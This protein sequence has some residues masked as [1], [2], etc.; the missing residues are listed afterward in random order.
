MNGDD[1]TD[2]PTFW[3]PV[4][5][6]VF[7][8]IQREV[9]L[10]GS[11]D[12]AFGA[13]L[14]GDEPSIS[15]GGTLQESHHQYAAPAGLIELRRSVSQSVVT[16]DGVTWD[17]ESEVTVVNGA[18]EGIFLVLNALLR[19]G[20][21]VVI[22]TPYFE[23]YAAV[24]NGCR[25]VVRE[26]PMLVEGSRF[27]FDWRAIASTINHRT[28]VLILNTPHNPTG[29]VLSKTD[30][31]HLAIAIAPWPRLAIVADEVY[32]RV[33]LHGRRHVS[34]AS[35]STCRDRVCV[36]SSISKAQAATGWRIGWVCAPCPL[37]STLRQVKQFLNY[38]SPAP[39]Q[40]MIASM[41]IDGT[42][43]QRAD[44]ICAA[45]QRR[46][47][48]VST[49]LRQVGLQVASSDG[50]YFV[51][52]RGLWPKSQSGVAGARAL[53]DRHRV[54]VLPIETLAFHGGEWSEWARVAC[55]RPWSVLSEGIDRIQHSL[56]ARS[57]L[58]LAP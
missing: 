27:A 13:P 11:V 5:E 39:L 53:F 58:R 23:A 30:L 21:E 55:C 56:R 32:D 19:P 6:S 2:A 40:M 51:A 48:F 17:P 57:I 41:M 10:P 46:V 52:V 36:L 8:Q 44:R 37:T 24:A 15:M 9:Q 54:R 28:R 50:T 38:C 45:Y 16:R 18:T 31:E 34:V 35:E 42:Y 14:L 3:P 25:A 49:S 26:V 29:A 33:L 7:A 12:L 20:D 1:R 4:Q 22:P 47:Q 43:D